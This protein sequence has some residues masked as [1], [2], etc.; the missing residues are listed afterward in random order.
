MHKPQFEIGDKVKVE[1]VLTGNMYHNLYEGWTHDHGI[2]VHGQH[3]EVKE[4]RYPT[5]G[6]EYIYRNPLIMVE[7]DKTIEYRGKST[8]RCLTLNA[9]SFREHELIKI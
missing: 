5:D 7:F 8:N 2:A 4:I 9:M 1:L 3:G 6:D